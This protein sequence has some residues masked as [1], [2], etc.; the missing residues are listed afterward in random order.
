[1]ETSPIVLILVSLYDGIGQREMSQRSRKAIRVQYPAAD[2][3][4]R[5]GQMVPVIAIDAGGLKIDDSRSDSLLD[6]LGRV[7]EQATIDHPYISEE[8]GQ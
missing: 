2:I 3:Q 7:W 5:S 8:A 4:Y 1:M 6:L